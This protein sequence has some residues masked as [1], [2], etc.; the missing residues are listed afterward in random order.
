MKIYL[1]NE[2][3]RGKG[4]QKTWAF[5]FYRSALKAARERIA[6]GGK[7]QAVSDHETSATDFWITSALWM[8]VTP[9]SLFF[10]TWSLK[11]WVRRRVHWQNLNDKKDGTQGSGWIHGRAWFHRKWNESRGGYGKRGR[12][13]C[14]SWNFEP[15][16]WLG[17]QMDL[18]D[19]DNER[20]IGF[21]L[22]LGF[23]HFWVTLE[24]FLS[25]EKAN[26]HNWAHT[27]G[28]SY[29]EDH[30]RVELHH[31]GADCW[32]CKGWKGWYWS[33]FVSDLIWG[34]AVYSSTMI[35]ERDAQVSMPE[36]AYLAKV[37]IANDQWKRPRKPWSNTIRRAHIDCPVGIPKPGKGENSWDCGQD[38]TYGLT[39]P[40]V[41][42]E[43]A[44]EKLRASVVRD[45]ERHGGKGWL[46]EGVTA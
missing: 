13:V 12:Q 24:N 21:S 8:S 29:F 1:L 14:F 36:G 3:E 46:P 23:A 41:S 17:A 7:W 25:R 43:E 15:R 20:D 19:G 31:A 34:S 2:G 6:E 16:W 32:D 28:I 22:H 38:A 18:F 11:Q 9:L 40:A 30:L 45:R 5:F 37:K 39:C 4:D 33:D 27:T 35:E 26:R 10:R 42:V 44:V